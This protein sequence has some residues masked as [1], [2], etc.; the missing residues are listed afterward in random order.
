MTLVLR[1]CK[2]LKAILAPPVLRGH[3]EKRGIL[4]K[5]AQLALRA[6]RGTPETSD[7]R[8]RRVTLVLRVLREILALRVK[9][10]RLA[11]TDKALTLPLRLV[12]T[13]TH[14]PISTPI[15]RPLRACPPRCHLFKEVDV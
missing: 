4:E 15:W 14:R 13:R 10:V 12:V 11:L 2:A 1:V 8:V 5:Q 9:R 7:L 3:R 6:R